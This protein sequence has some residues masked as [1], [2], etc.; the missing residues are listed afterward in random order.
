MGGLPGDEDA[1][2]PG[3]PEGGAEVPPAVGIAPGARQGR[4]RTDHKAAPEERP[5]PRQQAWHK[6]DDVLRPQRV[7]PRRDPVVEGVRP[8]AVS[9]QIPPVVLIGETFGPNLPGGEVHEEDS[10][11]VAA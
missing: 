3:P 8:Q 4:A 9:A 7:R 1:V 10:A 5:R 11:P 2:V 6:A